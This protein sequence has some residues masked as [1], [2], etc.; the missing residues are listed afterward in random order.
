MAVVL[1]Q[2]SNNTPNSAS[3]DKAMTFLIMLHYTCTGPFWGGIGFID[4]LD[5]GPN[6]NYPPALLWAS[7]F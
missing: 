2:F 5:F 4:V 7:G 3:V 1:W 6:K